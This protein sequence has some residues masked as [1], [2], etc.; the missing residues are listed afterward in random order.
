MPKILVLGDTHGHL[1][2]MIDA[3]QTEQIDFALQV[4]DFGAYLSTGNLSGRQIWRP[5]GDSN[6]GSSRERGVS[7]ASRR[8]GQE[9][10]N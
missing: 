3:M 6:P 4:G 2:K 10:K 5:H 7:W 9:A 1:D 8:W